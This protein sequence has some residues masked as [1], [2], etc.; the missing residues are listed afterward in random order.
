MDSLFEQLKE[1]LESVPYGE[2]NVKRH[3]GKSSVLDISSF[4]SVKYDSNEQAMAQLLEL[5]RQW[6]ES[7]FT[8]EMTFTIACDKGKIKRV[9]RQGHKRLFEKNQD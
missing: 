7:G 8:G 5:V 2:V 1:H 3:K 6:Q 9:I 4:E